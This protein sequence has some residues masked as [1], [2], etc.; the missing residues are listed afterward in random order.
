MN[1][2]GNIKKIVYFLDFPYGTGG[3]SRVLLTQAGIMNKLGYSTV[4]VIPDNEKGMH[5]SLYDELCAT[6]NLEIQTASYPIS[7]CMEGIDIE[8]VLKAYCEIVQ[9]L[10]KEKPDLIHSVQLNIAVEL[11]ARELG[12]PHLMNIYQTDLDTF[13]VGWMDVYPHYHSA[14]SALFVKRWREGLDISSQCIRVAYKSNCKIGTKTVTNS[15]A[16]RILMVGLVAEHKNQLEVLKFVKICKSIGIDVRLTVLGC[17]TNSYGSR[18]LEYVKQNNLE[19]E[20]A[21]QGFVNDV[22]SYFVQADLMIL[23]S[24]VESYPG[25]VVESMANKVPVISTPVAGIPELLVDEYNCFLTNGYCGEDI[26]EAFE[27]YLSYREKGKIKEIIESAYDCYLQNHSYEAIG[28]GLE[29]YY[30][31]ISKT[32]DNKDIC[33][34]VNYVR[35]EIENFVTERCMKEMAALTQSS[36]WFLYHI[37]KI[38][39]T[40]SFKKVLIW[41]AGFFGGIAIEW[42]E[43]VGCKDKLA[44][45]IDTYKTGTYLGYPILAEKEE[46]IKAAD[47][48]LMAI[49]DV[50]SCLENMKY[51]E[52]C[53][54]KRNKDYFL[55]QN[56][57]IR[58]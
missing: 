50:G 45:Y 36:L 42:L 43:I 3:S 47:M 7:T 28:D 18:C 53:G 29:C 58:I 24:V 13:N 57:P 52:R 9:L 46:A 56:A 12:I 35:S 4:I 25:V 8:E 22:E 23:S 19:R 37:Y 49:A 6:F 32:Y 44:G 2:A 55:M 14:D 38:N 41:G 26:F 33:I 21:F 48:I 5:I 27:R 15:H 16:I 40:V 31:W 34:K 1:S 20:V 30:D 54:K 51:L 17:N 39:Q 10:K 11:A